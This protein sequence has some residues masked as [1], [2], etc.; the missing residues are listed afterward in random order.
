MNGNGKAPTGAE[1]ITLDLSKAKNLIKSGGAL[2]REKTDRVLNRFGYIHNKNL[3]KTSRTAHPL[4]IYHEGETIMVADKFEDFSQAYVLHPWVYASVFAIASAGASVDF[5]IYKKEPDSVFAKPDTNSHFSKLFVKPNDFMAWYDF[6]ETSFTYLMLTGNLFWELVWVDGKIVEIYP[7][8]PHRMELVPDPATG[9]V[10]RYNYHVDQGQDS[11]IF[12]RHEILHIKFTHPLNDYFGLSPLNPV[13]SSLAT[14][15]YAMAF[16][17]NFF[18]KGAKVYGVL[19]TDRALTDPE[20]V[21]LREQWQDIYAGPLM[22]HKTALLEGGVKYKAI[23]ANAKDME[24]HEMREFIRKEVLAAQKVPETEI[25]FFSDKTTGLLQKRSFW[26]ETMEPLF[27]KISSNVTVFMLWLED[28]SLSCGFDTSG[29]SALLDT[30]KVRS[31]ID[32]KYVDTGLRLVNEL[33]ARDKLPPLP[34]GDTWHRPANRRAVSEMRPT[35]PTEQ[36]RH[37]R[38][39]PGTGEQEENAVSVES[40]PTSGEEP[41]RKMTET[42]ECSECGTK[43]QIPE[44]ETIDQYLCPDCDAELVEV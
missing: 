28:T 13:A 31:E 44:G 39:E 26:E 10:E 30:E 19:E 18:K 42:A 11:V 6:W 37:P 4:A 24:F 12:N 43:Y 8:M 20:F 21:K 23:G 34:Y 29:V 33:R 25:G 14:D 3:T 35:E 16:N 15:F 5:V 17:K 36:Q 27:K 41:K 7:L 9:I 1:Y 38:F 40:E 32:A 2:V 22:A